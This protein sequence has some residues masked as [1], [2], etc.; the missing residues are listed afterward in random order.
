MAIRSILINVEDVKRSVDFYTRYLGAEV[1]EASDDS[2]VLDAVA[3]QLRLVRLGAGAGGAGAGGAGGGDASTWIPDDLQAG[4][5][6]VG[7]K[8]ADMDARVDALHKGGVPFHLEPI[9]AEGDVRITFFYDPDGTLLELVE[10][11]LQYHE[12]FDREAVDADWALGTPTRPRFDHVAETVNDLEATKQYFGELGYSLMSGIHQPSDDRGFE[13]AFLRDGDT[14][15]EIFTYEK[16]EKSKRQ[17]QLEAPGFLAVEFEGGMPPGA[18]SVGTRAGLEI[19][20]DPDG[21]LH[22]VTGS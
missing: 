11:P 17:P 15:L 4:F 16:V 19:V 5:R 6:H 14:S 1:V 13:I 21:L 20:A 2:A 7:F 22:A 10:G 9:H 8:V 18:E 12:V 3:G